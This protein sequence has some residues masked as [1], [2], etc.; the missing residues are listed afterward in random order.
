MTVRGPIPTTCAISAASLRYSQGTAT[1]GFSITAQAYANNWN[2]ADQVRAAGHHDRDRSAFQRQLDPTD[3]GDT[4]RFSL[5]ARMAQ[6][7]D[8][9]SWKANAYFV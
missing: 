6:T 5:S 9:G 8:N 3:G 4:S 2:A 7:D 1:D